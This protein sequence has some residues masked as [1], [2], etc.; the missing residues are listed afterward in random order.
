MTDQLKMPAHWPP[1]THH[2][3]Y[4]M[5][6]MTSWDASSLTTWIHDHQDKNTD[7]LKM[8][9]HWP[10]EKNDKHYSKTWLTGWWCQLTDHLKQMTNTTAR[11]D[12]PAKMSANWPPHIHD[13]HYCKTWLTGWRCQLIDHLKHR[14]IIITVTFKHLSLKA[15][16]PLQDHEGGGGTE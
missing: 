5:T 3:H 15:V 1:E 13:K 12:W 10:P 7:R 16:S 2:N 14:I 8:S 4:S 6:W 9:A 11:C